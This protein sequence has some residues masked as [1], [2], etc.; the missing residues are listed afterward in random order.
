MT[1]II[2]RVRK[3]ACN[4]LNLRIILNA[5]GNPHIKPILYSSNPSEEILFTVTMNTVF[6]IKVIYLKQKK[7]IRKTHISYMVSLFLSV[8]FAC[9]CA[10][11]SKTDMFFIFVFALHLAYWWCYSTEC[12]CLTACE[13]TPFTLPVSY[14]LGDSFHIFLSSA[15]KS[16][17]NVFS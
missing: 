17:K 15:E 14:E 16:G 7:T 13:G 8:Y 2:M 10:V 4:C 6:I 12:V 1:C 3:V 9:G 5:K 11:F